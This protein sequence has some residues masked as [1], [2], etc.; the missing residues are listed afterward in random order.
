MSTHT[1]DRWLTGEQQMDWRAYLEGN[2][3]LW[4]AL[5][6]DLLDACGLSLSEY[7]IL[8]RLSEKPGHAMRMS[9]LADELA[10]SRSRVS[11]TVRRME[12]RQLVA[13]KPSSSDRR[14]I[15]CIMTAQGYSLLKSAAPK[16]VASVRDRLVDVITSDELAQ[17][18]AIFR[19]V[20]LA[21]GRQTSDISNTQAV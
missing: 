1:F 10:Q 18:A 8:V 19:R 14:G 12:E 2:A 4:D 16:H 20:A 6:Y 3:I 7:E 17:L 21:S 11:H 15:N 13:R 5:N 9:A